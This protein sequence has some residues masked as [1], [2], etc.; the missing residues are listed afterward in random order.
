VER[1]GRAALGV[2]AGDP[3]E[4]LFSDPPQGD[5]SPPRGLTDV[6]RSIQQHLPGAVDSSFSV[7]GAKVRSGHRRKVMYCLRLDPEHMRLLKLVKARD[8]VT[9]SDQIRLAL[10]TWFAQKGVVDEVDG[11]TEGPKV[12]SG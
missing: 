9:Q 7:T 4:N 5:S 1:I 12:S 3:S 6:M 8:G 11:V 2:T 10:A